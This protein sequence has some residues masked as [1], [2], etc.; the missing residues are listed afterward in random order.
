MPA[1]GLP[2]DEVDGQASSV[3]YEKLDDNLI[4][5]MLDATCAQTAP[6]DAAYAFPEYNT[7]SVR[8]GPTYAAESSGRWCG[9]FFFKK[10]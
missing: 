5:Y 9:I 7:L 10:K 2:Y 1:A 4:M 3:S 6:P 8:S